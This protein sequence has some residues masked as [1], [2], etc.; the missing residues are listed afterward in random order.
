LVTLLTPPESKETLVNFYERCRP[1][2]LWKPVREKAHLSQTGDPSLG[3]LVFDCV[4]GTA[5]CFGLVVAT[6]SMFA[7]TWSVFTVGLIAAAGFGIWLI[8]RILI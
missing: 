3:H 5:A 6:N 2:G 7:G 8:K 1:P 4:L